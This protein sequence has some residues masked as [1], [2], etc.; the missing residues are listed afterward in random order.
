MF[1]TRACLVVFTFFY[2]STILQTNPTGGGLILGVVLFP[3]KDKLLR[4]RPE[5]ARGRAG[6]GREGEVI[7]VF[8]L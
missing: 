1:L 5:G 8:G 6:D 4:R 3:S 2:T 7:P